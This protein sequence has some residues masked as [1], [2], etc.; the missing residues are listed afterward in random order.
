MTNN[1]NQT[2]PRGAQPNEDEVAG[3]GGSS[4]HSPVTTADKAGSI[5][6]MRALALALIIVGLLLVV[7][8]TTIWKG[9]DTV[10]VLGLASIVGGFFTASKQR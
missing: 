5:T 3:S 6:W 2:P 10:L 1:G 4:L 9:N 7:A 8:S